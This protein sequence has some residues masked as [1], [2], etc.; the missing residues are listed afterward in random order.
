MRGS[1]N[2]LVI[3]ACGGYCED[4]WPLA[5][6]SPLAMGAYLDMARQGVI[7]MLYPVVIRRGKVHIYYQSQ[8]PHDWTRG[9][10]GKAKATAHAALTDERDLLE[11]RIAGLL[12]T[13]M[14]EDLQL[15]LDRAVARYNE[16]QNT[17][18][19]ED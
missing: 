4:V 3:E 17:L 11:R 14:T 9:L 1:A 5:A 19:L 2:E 7:E 13:T 16:I 12:E 15:V 18:C 10:L 8:F 6:A